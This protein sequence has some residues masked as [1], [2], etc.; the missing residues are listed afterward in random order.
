[1]TRQVITL[2]KIHKC[3][4]VESGDDAGSFIYEAST[5]YE[6]GTLVFDNVNNMFWC[7]IVPIEDTDT[8][9][10]LD[11]PDKW[12]FVPFFNIS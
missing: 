12:A 10:P 4:V 5:A 1:M 2:D 6:A 11:A 9:S 8:D 3:H 7:S